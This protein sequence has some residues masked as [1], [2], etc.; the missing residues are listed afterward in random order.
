MADEEGIGGEALAG[1]VVVAFEREMRVDHAV[2]RA[3]QAVDVP[4]VGKF[5]LRRKL[6]VIRA[7]RDD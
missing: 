1:A 3:I 6:R 4:D 5:H 7:V 2:G